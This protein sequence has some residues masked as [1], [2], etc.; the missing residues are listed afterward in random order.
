[1]I[2]V[3]LNIQLHLVNIQKITENLPNYQV[4][5]FKTTL[6]FHDHCDYKNINC[7]NSFRKVEMPKKAKNKNKTILNLHISD[8]VMRIKNI[9]ILLYNLI[10]I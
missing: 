9:Y 2:L 4:I 7:D 3:N 5:I 1:M 8:I 10:F 6:H